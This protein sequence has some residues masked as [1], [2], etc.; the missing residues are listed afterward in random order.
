[1]LCCKQTRKDSLNL[2]FRSLKSTANPRQFQSMRNSPRAGNEAHTAPERKRNTLAPHMHQLISY[3]AHNT[4]YGGINRRSDRMVTVRPIVMMIGS[5]CGYIL[6]LVNK[7]WEVACVRR[8][9]PVVTTKN[10]ELYQ[11]KSSKHTEKNARSPQSFTCSYSYIFIGG[12]RCVCSQLNWPIIDT[13]NLSMQHVHVLQLTWL[14]GS[15]LF[16]DHIIPP[17]HIP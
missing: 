1:M 7:L 3:W 6:A 16:S 13:C 12:M 14:G 17:S 15:S 2:G 8:E 5:F 10:I 4:G 11:Y 9:W